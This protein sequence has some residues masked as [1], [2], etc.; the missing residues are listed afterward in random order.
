M[1]TNSAAWLDA[2]FADLTVRPAPYTSP[3][4]EEIVIRNRAVAV[5][6]LDVVKQATGDLM[7]RWLPYPSVL[8]EDVAGEVVEVGSNV[9]RFRVGDRVLAYA[10][11]MEKGRRHQ[12]E[13]GFQ[14]YTVARAALAAPIP[15]GMRFED[16]AVLPLAVS[17]AASAMFQDDQLG[18]VDP[19][20]AANGAGQ[21]VVVWGGA[22]SVGTNAIQLAVAAGYTVVTTASPSNH[23]RMRALGA[24][25]VF[26][27]RSAAVVKDVTEALRGLPVAGI[28]A[29]GTG[30]AEPSVRI[31]AA[32]G[33]KRVSM[34]SPAVSFTD[35]PRRAGI[36]RRYLQVMG[37]LVTSNVRLQAFCL[38]HGIRARFV[39][40]SSLMDNK[41]GPMLW[42]RFLP[43]ALAEGRYI[44]A[45]S[46]DVVGTGLGEVQLALDA[47]GRGVSARKLIVLL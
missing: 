45:P 39:W 43:A 5:N 31:A 29:V 12:A 44:A 16:A 8:G 34:A 17:T 14:L 36:G 10:I 26:D 7:Y 11:G 23:D 4:A 24:D 38:T 41:V 22:T 27:Y 13:G 1:P 25:H 40:G 28:L 2:R 42:E 35:L 47:L 20:A 46:P 37:K 6:P 18:L 30:S 15:A 21:V 3:A 33:A 9:T 32:T 19:T